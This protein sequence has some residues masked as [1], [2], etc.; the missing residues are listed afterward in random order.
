MNNRKV[1][2]QHNSAESVKNE[3]IGSAL[4]RSV[5]ILGTLGIS[6]TETTSSHT[7]LK[8]ELSESNVGPYGAV[9]GLALVA[10]TDMSACIASSVAWRHSGDGE[11]GGFATQDV[12]VSFCR[13]ARIGPI[14]IKAEIKHLSKRRAVVNIIAFDHGQED[15]IVLT[16]IVTVARLHDDQLKK[17]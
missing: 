12:A 3:D 13:P 15:V 6:V 11:L 14:F 9:L 16:E 7:T 17:K 10:A 4:L 1:D 8:L 5:P 2:S